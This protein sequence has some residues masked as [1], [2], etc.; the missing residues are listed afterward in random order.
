[1][2]MLNIEQQAGVLAGIFRMKGYQ[3]PFQLMPLSSHQVLSSGPLEKCL[4]EYISMCERRKRAMD[5]FRLLSDVRLGKPQ[6]LY[7][8]EMQLSHRVEEGFRIN[9]LT[10]HS[11]HGISKKQPV[12]GTYNLP[13]VH[14][15][16]PPHGNS[17]KQRVLPPPPRRRR[18]L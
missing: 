14:Q 1:M 2:S 9:H 6:Q 15:L 7:R 16:L 3:P 12:N 18:G 17:H 4:H 10:L 11:M 5:D 8:L 13:S